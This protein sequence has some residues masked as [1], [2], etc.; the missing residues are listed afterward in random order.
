MGGKDVRQSESQWYLGY[1]EHS[2]RAISSYE[3]I[4]EASYYV[5]ITNAE[6]LV[7][8]GRLVNAVLE[9]RKMSIGREKARAER[10]RLFP[11]G[12]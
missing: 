7:T 8:N 6:G 3:E 9:R 10:T 1:D 5:L 4:R 11:R 12:K 2:W